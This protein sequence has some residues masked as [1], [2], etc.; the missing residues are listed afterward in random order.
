VKKPKPLFVRASGAPFSDEDAQLI[1]AELLKI[2]EANRIDDVR[3]LDKKIVFAVVE[4]DPNHPLR[5][6]YDWDVKKAARK[7]WV[8]WTQKLI[9]SVRIEYKIGKFTRPLPI[10]LAAELPRLKFGATR[11][12]VLTADAMMN[13]PIFASAVGLRLRNIDQNLAQLESLIAAHEGGPPGVERLLEAMRS[14]FDS[15]YSS[16]RIAAE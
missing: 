13:D 12:R 9:M 3:L 7:H 14:A 1:G 16:L 6:F 15:Y 11:R 10:T 2:A 5:K 4:A 8:E